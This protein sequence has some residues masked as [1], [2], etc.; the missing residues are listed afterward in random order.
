MR[1]ALIRLC[2]VVLCVDLG[3]AQFLQYL[4]DYELGE[5]DYDVEMLNIG[6]HL[7]LLGNFH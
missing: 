1:Q 6:S 2:V 3:F 4:R 5:D 7:G